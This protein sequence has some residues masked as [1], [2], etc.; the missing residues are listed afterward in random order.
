MN[1]YKYKIKWYNEI[2]DKIED[3]SG[4]VFG[5]TYLEAMKNLIGYYGNQEIEK[6]SLKYVDD[7]DYPIH[8]IKN[9][10]FQ[11]N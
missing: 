10:I 4:F 6:V 9:T 11:D 2:D 1:K 3:I 8:E 7:T 5:E